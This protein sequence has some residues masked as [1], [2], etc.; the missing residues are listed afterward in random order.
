MRFLA[1]R[2]ILFAL[3]AGA[4]VALWSW[5]GEYYAATYHAAGMQL[6][7]TIGA[8]WVVVLHPLPE[9]QGRFDT[10]LWLGNPK[11][12]IHGQR[13]LSTRD[14]GYAPTT[15]LLALILASPVP[16][17]R[18]FGATFVGLVVVHAWIALGVLLL[19]IS[20]F[21]RGDALAIFDLSP[22]VDRC[23][24]Y[25][26]EVATVATIT[27][28]A[29]PTVIWILVTFRSGDWARIVG[30][31]RMPQRRNDGAAP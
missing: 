8:D 3:V 30:D 24:S 16:W 23:L 13:Q 18:R 29:V 28:Y 27:K 20:G 26:V 7:R 1:S 11:T 12:K 15:M 14:L 2:F 4:F 25:C 9:P 5:V 10:E 17:R 21:S 22:F 31:E 6:C 19:V